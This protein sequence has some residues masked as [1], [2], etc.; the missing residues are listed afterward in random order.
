MNSPRTAHWQ[1]T[2]LDPAPQAPSGF[3][4]LSTPT[5]RGSTT[6]FDRARDVRDDWC[7]ERVPYAY[8]LH[9]TPTT[10]ELARRIAAL[11]GANHCFITPGGQAALALIYLAFCKSGDHVLVPE[12]AYGPNNDLARDL[13]ARL[14]IEVQPYDPLIGADIAGLLRA[15]T[16]LVWCESPG[17]ATMEVQDIP[18]IVA[19]ARQVGAVVALDNTYSAGVLFDAFGH[20]VDVST[21]ALTKYIGGHSDLLLGSVSTCSPEHYQ[22]LGNA[23]SLLGLAAS[24]DDCSL[25]LRGLQTLAVRLTHL[26]QATLAVARWLGT[27]PEVERV[28]H[29][30]LPDCPGHELWKRDF[31]GSSSVFSVV[32]NEAFSG[33]RLL[34]F[35]D[36]LRLFHIGYSWGG[37]TSLVAPHF[38]LRREH[39]TY[40]ERL[41]R[42]NIGLEAIDDLIADLEQAFATLHL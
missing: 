33:E 42:F 37:V 35:I 24:P 16:A 40:G 7:P 34:D 4:S 36:Q 39:R 8:G 28:L 15:N 2:L 21:Q 27:R 29:P 31:S 23:R 6:L 10:L 12:S 22:A 30:A 26:E 13:L 18:A 38:N 17:S 25:A 14:G 9:G 11:E 41:V 3:K 20:G 5:Y 1:T 19:A 32:F